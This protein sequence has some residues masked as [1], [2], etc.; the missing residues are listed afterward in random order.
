MMTQPPPHQ[1]PTDIGVGAQGL[2]DPQMQKGWKAWPA[3]CLLRCPT[4]RKMMLPNSGRLDE[5]A[6]VLAGAQGPDLVTG[7]TLQERNPVDSSPDGW[8][9]RRPSKETT[10]RPHRGWFG[11]K[12]PVQGRALLPPRDARPSI[13]IRCAV[14]DQRSH[15]AGI[16][17]LPKQ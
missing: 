14:R 5:R 17:G 11:P 10:L 15:H 12:D 13:P 7:W 9:R 4:V 3:R 8:L 2:L 1:V 6:R 16:G